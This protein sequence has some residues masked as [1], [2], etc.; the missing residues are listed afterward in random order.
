MQFTGYRR[1][2][3]YP[4]AQWLML[5]ATAAGSIWPAEGRSQADPNQDEQVRIVPI[6]EIVRTGRSDRW[7]YQLSPDGDR[8][9]WLTRRNDSVVVQV[10]LQGGP[11][12]R[13]IP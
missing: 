3:A 12:E 5:Y 7:D 9:A 2:F 4:V 1:C 13:S 6:E 8:L 10:S 11:P